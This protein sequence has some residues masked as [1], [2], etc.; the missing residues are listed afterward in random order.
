VIRVS[1]GPETS[2]ANVDRFLETWTKIG[3]PAAHA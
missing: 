2:V 3:R 1:F